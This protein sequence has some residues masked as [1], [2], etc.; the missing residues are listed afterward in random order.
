MTIKITLAKVTH[1]T[2][3][4]KLT[5]FKLNKNIELCTTTGSMF[6]RKI[7]VY[8]NT[9]YW[10][11]FNDAINHIVDMSVAVNGDE[12]C[13]NLMSKHQNLVNATEAI[14]N[15]YS[16]CTS[17][18]LSYILQFFGVAVTGGWT[19]WNGIQTVN[20]LFAWEPVNFCISLGMTAI[21][22][23]VTS[24]QYEKLTE[25]Q[26]SAV[27]A[28]EHFKSALNDFHAVVKA[29]APE[30]M[31]DYAVASPAFNGIYHKIYRWLPKMDV[32]SMETNRPNWSVA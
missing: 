31:R 7:D 6:D 5:Y 11:A 16:Q 2:R 25:T 12:L 15:T 19:I 1:V 22:S 9:W 24:A 21:T 17:T 28:T 14:T 20:A 13:T 4:R 29:Y 8:S 30:S 23:V 18:Q 3:G 27:K 26:K 32:T 10:F